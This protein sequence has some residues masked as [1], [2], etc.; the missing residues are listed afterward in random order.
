M[1]EHVAVYIDFENIAIS[2]EEAYGRCDLDKVLEVAAK[3]G[4]CVVKKA[5][6]D[7][8][9]FSRYRQELIEHAIDLTQLFRY[10]S[11]SKK[12]SADIVMA[13]DALE[14]AITRQ[15][16]NTF[17]L[18]TGDSDFS[19][20]A[21]KLREYGNNIRSTCVPARVRCICLVRWQSSIRTQRMNGFGS[22]FFRLPRRRLT[23]AVAPCSV[24]I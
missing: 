6:G 22:T 15:G 14:T 20:V 18:V 21:R 5:Y 23:R 9:R 11:Y 17:V 4:R 10:G 2:A 8:T 7:W 3:Y 12:N 24:I 19:A 13:V 1:E 16:I